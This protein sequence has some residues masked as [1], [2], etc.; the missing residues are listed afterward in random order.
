M[1]E[2]SAIPPENEGREA[3]A[4]RPRPLQQCRARSAPPSHSPVL[5]PRPASPGAAPRRRTRR[6]ST[7]GGAAQPCPQAHGGGRRRSSPHAPGRSAGPAP[8][9]PRAPYALPARPPTQAWRPHSPPRSAPAP[10]ASGARREGGE[11]TSGETMQR[12]WEGDH[13]ARQRRRLHSTSVV[14]W[15]RGTFDLRW[16]LDISS[17]LTKTTLLRTNL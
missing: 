14:P 2:G 10:H 8:L 7:V 1:G 3:A 17:L 15:Q 5:G 9:P 6:P 4:A 13:F 12:S 16:Q 11:V